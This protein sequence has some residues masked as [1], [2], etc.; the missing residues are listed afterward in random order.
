MV[1]FNAPSHLRIRQ[2]LDGAYVDLFLLAGR[3]ASGNTRRVAAR[4]G[5]NCFFGLERAL[6]FRAICGAFKQERHTEYL[7][8]QNNLRREGRDGRDPSLKNIGV[9][10]PAAKFRCWQQNL[11]VVAQ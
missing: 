4:A 9:L 3:K 10:M 8:E 5:S 7:K 1:A 2:R 11:K 6:C